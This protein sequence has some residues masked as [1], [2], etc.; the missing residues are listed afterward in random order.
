GKIVISGSGLNDSQSDYTRIL[1]RAVDVN[2]RIQANK[3]EITTGKNTLDNDGNV[4]SQDNSAAKQNDYAIDV[5]LV[6][7][8]YANKIKLVGTEHGVGVRNAGEIGAEA[9]GLTLNENGQLI[10]TGLIQSQTQLQVD[11][12]SV[13]NQG[14][15]TGDKD[16]ALNTT[17]D[18]VNSGMLQAKNNIQLKATE[19]VSQAASGKI[20]AQEN[21][22]IDAKGYLA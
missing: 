12:A 19:N 13:N 5:A 9:G 7:G 20:L 21:I 17:G 15:I 3:L 18:L 6:G 1:A 16:L 10:N 4:I 2:S 8:M 22:Q 11:T 14:V